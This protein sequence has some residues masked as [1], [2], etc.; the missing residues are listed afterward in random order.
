MNIDQISPWISLLSM[1]VS[2]GVA[3]F[4]IYKSKAEVRNIQADTKKIEADTAKTFQDMLDKEIEKGES[5]KSTIE[6]LKCK[7]EKLEHEVERLR[8]DLEARDVGISILIRQILNRGEEPEWTPK[9]D[10]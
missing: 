2:I 7:I 6:T 10:K 8:K 5:M 4:V 9:K 3:V 1:V